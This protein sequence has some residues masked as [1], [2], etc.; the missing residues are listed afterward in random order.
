ML[1]SYNKEGLSLLKI[2]ENFV[3]F[4]SIEEISSSALCL[5]TICLT[6]DKPKPVFPEFLDL[7]SSTL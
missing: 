2:I 3:P 4:P 6:I 1:F 5:L 7:A